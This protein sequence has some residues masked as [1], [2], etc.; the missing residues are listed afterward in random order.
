[1]FDIF[2]Y[3]V[4]NEPSKLLR[5]DKLVKFSSDCAFSMAAPATFGAPNTTE[6]GQQ[7]K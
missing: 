7:K 1:L 3:I 4:E 6:T 5:V 2:N